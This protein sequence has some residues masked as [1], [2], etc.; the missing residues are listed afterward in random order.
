MKREREFRR[1]EHDTLGAVL[2]TYDT[3][4]N[5]AKAA[6]QV[7]QLADE[8]PEGWTFHKA[9]LKRSEKGA[10]ISIA[11]FYRLTKANQTVQSSRT[12]EPR[13]VP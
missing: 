3:A 1:L 9:Q 2:V 10:R 11:V 13:K 6:I 5:L 8:R 12:P 4:P 7:V